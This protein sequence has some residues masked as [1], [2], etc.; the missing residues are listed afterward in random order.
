MRICWVWM[1]LVVIFAIVAPLLSLYT[2]IGFILFVSIASSFIVLSTVFMIP[3]ILMMLRLKRIVKIVS[4]SRL[5]RHIAADN[6][7]FV[8][9]G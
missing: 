3:E 5:L 9:E 8:G 1:I 2:S 7:I 4:Y 6:A